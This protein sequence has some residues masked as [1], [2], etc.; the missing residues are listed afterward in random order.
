MD[1]GEARMALYT[2]LGIIEEAPD[3]MFDVAGERVQGLHICFE[4]ASDL[5]GS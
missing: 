4:W 3:F 5:I 1:A 2:T